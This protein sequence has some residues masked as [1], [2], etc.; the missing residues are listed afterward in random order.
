M[1]GFEL[2]GR[3]MH[4][5]GWMEVTRTCKYSSCVRRF[6]SFSTQ[7]LVILIAAL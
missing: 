1:H 3:K 7:I 6:V 5:T 4:V 2:L